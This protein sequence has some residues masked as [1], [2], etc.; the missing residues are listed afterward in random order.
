MSPAHARAGTLDTSDDVDAEGLPELS[1]RVRMCRLRRARFRDHD[2]VV[3]RQ[4]SPHRAE[5]FS[6]QAL[7]AI[8]FD[9][10]PDASADRD[11]DAPER[12]R[13]RGAQYDE[14]LRVLAPARAL[15]AQKVVTLPQP[16]ALREA[17]RRARCHPGCFGG[18]DAVS[19]FRPFA[20]RRFSTCRPPGVAIR[21]RNPCVRFR[22]RL[23][24]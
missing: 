21:A 23:L 20:R 4:S 8:S 5:H 11:A 2:H 17:R 6:H 12:T 3:W 10:V 16:R 18:T 7:D 19:R 15:Y 9:G 24:G 22:R 13:T 1:F 14:V